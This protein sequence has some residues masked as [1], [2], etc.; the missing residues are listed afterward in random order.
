M[1]SEQNTLG[2]VTQSVS[3]M[4]SSVM[5]YSKTFIHFIQLIQVHSKQQ[6]HKKIKHDKDY[7]YYLMLI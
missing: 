3:Q 2:I 4:L 1:P 5:T 6:M 7:I